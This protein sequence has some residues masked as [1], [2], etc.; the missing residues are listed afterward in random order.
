MHCYDCQ[1]CHSE[2]EQQQHICNLCNGYDEMILSQKLPSILHAI[3]QLGLL[4][5]L[6]NFQR[7]SNENWNDEN[8]NMGRLF[9]DNRVDVQ[10]FNGTDTRC[11]VLRFQHEAQVRGLF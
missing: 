10:V 3:Q 6:K 7:N 5:W 2:H 9:K 4:E 8:T 1:F 11:L